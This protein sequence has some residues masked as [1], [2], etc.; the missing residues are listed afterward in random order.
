MGARQLQ[1][2]ASIPSWTDQNNGDQEKNHRIFNNEGRLK[3][4]ID[5]GS[6]FISFAIQSQSAFAV[7]I[8]LYEHLNV[9]NIGQLTELATKSMAQQCSSGQ[10]KNGIIEKNKSGGAADT[11]KIPRNLLMHII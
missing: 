5:E 10:Q 4:H 9:N 11:G 2:D 1:S 8:V 6:T 7:D 3:N